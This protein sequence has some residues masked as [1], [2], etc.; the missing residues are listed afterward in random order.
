MRVAAHAAV[1][2][3]DRRP[4][5]P[6]VRRLEDIWLHI[7]KGMPI[8]RCISRARVMKAGFHPRNPGSFRQIENIT[9]NVAP[10][11]RAVARH[12]EIPVIGPNPDGLTIARRLADRVDRCVRLRVRIVDRNAAGFFLLLFLRIIGGQI[13]RDALP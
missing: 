12:L 7:S 8:D 5:F 1:R 9:N 13:R 11:L 3:D 2:S 4:G 6:V 10:G